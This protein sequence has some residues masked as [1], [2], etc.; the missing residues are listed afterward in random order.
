MTLT[1]EQLAKRGEIG[2]SDCPAIVAGSNDDR[3]KLWR[4]KVGLQD[5][6]DLTWDW[7]AYRGTNMEDPIRRWQ[8]HKLGYEFTRVGEV[9][10]H[11]DPKFSFLTCTL[12]GYD[13]V[14]KAV[15]EIKT[16]TSL[17][18][19][20]RWYAAQFAVQRAIM[21]VPVIMLVSVMAHEPV[22]IEID[23]DQAFI[24]ECFTRIAAFKICVETV[25]QP[26]PVEPVYPP[27]KWRTVDLTR[28]DTNYKDEMIE[29][30]TV[31]AAT[32]LPADQNAQAAE[33]A[34]SLVPNDVGRL[35]FHNISINRNKRGHLSI[36]QKDAA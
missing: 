1:P 36:Q 11:Q 24:D 33:S 25:T 7:P 19:A 18:W 6:D 20:Q 10:R 9:F 3:N 29:H 8:E 34:K 5:A 15:I 31:W 23:H 4:I 30:L 27:E 14:R 32:K 17:D 28:E 16:A 21:R 22:E 12:D 2:A 13:P 35:R 26:H